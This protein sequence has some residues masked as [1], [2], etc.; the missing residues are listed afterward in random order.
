MPKNYSFVSKALAFSTAAIFMTACSDKPSDPELFESVE[1]ESIAMNLDG[2]W[3]H[4]PGHCSNIL[5]MKG[6][7]DL[8]IDG[9]QVML[10]DLGP[11]WTGQ[12]KAANANNEFAQRI[13]E[14]EASC[15]NLSVDTQ[16]LDYVHLNTR[17]KTV[18]FAFD[19]ENLIVGEDDAIYWLTRFDASHLQSLDIHDNIEWDERE[20]PVE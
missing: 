18:R 5:E 11:A 13:S 7:F 10:G 15:E 3:L 16:S 9:G 6:L 1:V 19:N 20:S 2:H 4:N 14:Y 12:F 17:S 8:K